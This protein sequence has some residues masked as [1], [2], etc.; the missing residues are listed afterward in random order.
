MKYRL[1]FIALCL[2]ASPSISALS[3]GQT[4]VTQNYSP[5]AQALV[6]K[7]AGKI[8][9]WQHGSTIGREIFELH[10]DG[11]LWVDNQLPIAIISHSRS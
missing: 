8:C 6:A 11:K 7:L 10:A 3:I 4:T 9:T 5:Q 2:T 1:R